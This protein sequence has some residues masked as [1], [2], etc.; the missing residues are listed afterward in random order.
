LLGRAEV[1][2]LRWEC[3]RTKCI[4]RVKTRSDNLGYSLHF[5]HS[6]FKINVRCR[7]GFTTI[8]HFKEYQIKD[9]SLRNASRNTV[10]R[11]WSIKC[12]VSQTFCSKNICMCATMLHRRDFRDGGVSRHCSRDKLSQPF[13]IV[14]LTK[15]RVKIDS[16]KWDRIRLAFLR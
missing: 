6:T 2:V 8:T 16:K 5:E 7:F 4:V 3:V 9:T 13:V 14:K 12:K 10:H 15:K 1:P 11:E